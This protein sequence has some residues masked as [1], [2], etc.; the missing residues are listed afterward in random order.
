ML[1]PPPSS[2]PHAPPPPPAAASSAPPPTHT[3]RQTHAQIRPP[4]PRQAA[5]SV[6][7]RHRPGPTEK[8][9]EKTAQQR[10]SHSGS[11][12]MLFLHP[13][14]HTEEKRCG[15]P[16]PVFTDA[17]SAKP[18]RWGLC[19]RSPR[20]PQG[21]PQ[22]PSSSTRPKSIKCVIASLTQTFLSSEAADEAGKKSLKAKPAKPVYPVSLRL[23][24]KLP[25]AKKSTP[26]GRN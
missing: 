7:P 15:H 23:P 12:C 26:G 8:L 4:H 18:P 17:A 9:P 24:L 21:A 6:W 3:H 10:C 14:A 22:L 2:T 13:D 5:A 19:L 25:P 16:R 11:P 1:T 20:A